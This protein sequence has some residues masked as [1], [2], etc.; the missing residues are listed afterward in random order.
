M[1]LPSFEEVRDQALRSDVRQGAPVPVWKI[2]PQ[3]GLAGV[4][5]SAFAE[6]IDAPTIVIPRSSIPQ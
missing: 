1:A 6:L 4:S 3:A 2:D 5:A